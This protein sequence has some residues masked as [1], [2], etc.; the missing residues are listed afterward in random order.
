MMHLSLANRFITGELSS[1]TDFSSLPWPVRV[2]E[3]DTCVVELTV[4]STRADISLRE[5][6]FANHSAWLNYYGSDGTRKKV[7][8]RKM[9]RRKLREV[10]NVVYIVCY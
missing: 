8:L 10:H 3:S 2:F 7:D 1:P 4:V 9:I 5:G 6:Q